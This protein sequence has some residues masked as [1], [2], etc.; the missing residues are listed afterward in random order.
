MMRNILYLSL[1]VFLF[2]ACGQKDEEQQKTEEPKVSIEH[3]TEVQAPALTLRPVEFKDLKNWYRDDF[4]EA[5]PA[6]KSSC[7][8]ILK[9][10]NTYMS[11][12]ELQIPT[13]A[14]QQACKRLLNSNISTSSELRYFLDKMFSPYLVLDKNSADG[15][16]TAYYESSIDVS[17]EQSPRYPYPIYSRPQDL[18]ELNLGDFDSRYPNNK[19]YGR[20]N[21]EKTKLIPYYTR[22]EIENNSDNLKTLEKQIQKYK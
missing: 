20:L 2:S 6:I 4:V 7:E 5:L 14:Y 16:F 3:Q 19:I 17:R 11:N 18:V 13:E 10:N 15:K 22:A 1:L 9:E 12:S 8:Q 21:A